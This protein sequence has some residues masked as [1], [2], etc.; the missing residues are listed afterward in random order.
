MF[1]SL[2]LGMGVMI[3]YG[4]YLS[5]KEKIVN[6]AIMIPAADTIVAL[7]AGLAVLPAAF[8]L[9]GEE[10][11][12]AGPKL[13]FVTLQ[14]VFDAMGAAGPIFGFLFYFL[15]FIAA[16]T[17]SISLVEVITAYFLDRAERKQK[18]GNRKVTALLVSIAIMVLAAVV[19]ADGLG[20]NGMVQPLGYCWL[21][22]MD[23]W[24]EG[25][26]MHLS[27]LLMT[28]FIGMEYGV[29]KI[30]DEICLEG[31][32]FKSKGFYKFCCYYVVPVAMVFI[33]VGQLQG[34]GIL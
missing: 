8:A 7:M 21:D 26:M 3:T 15:V 17:S 14:N 30:A 12:M 25:I 9:G 33:L 19:A 16:I 24:S 20:S 32:R 23:L 5:K 11:A 28:I 29:D 10:A 13:L 18:K 1:F 6:N 4:S 34:F 22:F 31:N 2:S 27:A